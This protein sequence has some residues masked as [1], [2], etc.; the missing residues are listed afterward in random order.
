[1]ERFAYGLHE[2]RYYAAFKACRR[3]V[4]LNPEA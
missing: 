3:P 2:R 4:E 1:M